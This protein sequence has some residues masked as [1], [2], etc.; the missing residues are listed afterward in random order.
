M[1]GFLVFECTVVVY[2]VHVL[3]ISMKVLRI[4]CV[5]VCTLVYM[6]GWTGSV[7]QPAFSHLGVCGGDATRLTGCDARRGSRSWSVGAL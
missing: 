5:F 6:Y 4:A 1:S 2:L 3:W 7:S